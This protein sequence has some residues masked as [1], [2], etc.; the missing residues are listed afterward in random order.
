M[1]F[2][3]DWAKGKTASYCFTGMKFR[4]GKVEV[5]EMHGGDGRTTV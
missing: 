5:L 1:V 2:A 4:F 3:R